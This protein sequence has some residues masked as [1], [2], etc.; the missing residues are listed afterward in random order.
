MPKRPAPLFLARKS[1]RR[2]RMMDAAR[3]LPLAGIFFIL[4]PILWQPRETPEPD[5]G[6]GLVYLFVIWSLLIIVARIVSQMLSTPPDE[7]GDDPDNGDG[8][9]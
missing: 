8:M 4:L 9:A 3:L 2:R 1:Y 7:T 5:T 6:F